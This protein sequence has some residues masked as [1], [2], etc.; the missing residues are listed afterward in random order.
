MS[1]RVLLVDDHPVVRHGLRRMLEQ[2]EDIKV[3]G[4]AVSGEEALAQIE[5]ISPSII[6]MD[7]KM[8]GMGGIEAIHQIK[9]RYPEINIIV[10]T[11]YGDQYLAQA[12]ESGATGYLVKDIGGEDLI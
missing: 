6:L 3:V 7:I 11:L 4:E 5:S 10:L 12:I 1:I 8:P 9:E 2:E